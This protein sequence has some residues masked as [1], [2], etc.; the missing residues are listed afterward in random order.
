MIPTGRSGEGNCVIRR[1]QRSDH[2]VCLSEQCK[3]DTRCAPWARS[4]SDVVARAEQRIAKSELELR[5]LDTMEA[6]CDQR[7]RTDNWANTRALP[8]SAKG[9]QRTGVASVVNRKPANHPDGAVRR[10]CKQTL[11]QHY[12]KLTPCMPVR[13]RAKNN[14]VFISWS[15]E[16]SRTIATALQGFLTGLVPGVGV[17]SSLLLEPGEKWDHEI[18]KKLQESR[19]FILCLTSENLAAPWIHFEARGQRICPFLIDGAIMKNLQPPLSTYQPVVA[20]KKGSWTLV[21]SISRFFLRVSPSKA[22]EAAFSER[23]PRFNSA[24]RSVRVPPPPPPPPRPPPPKDDRIL[25]LEA[26][27][28][29][30]TVVC[31]WGSVV[32]P[33]NLDRKKTVFFLQAFEAIKNLVH[34]EIERQS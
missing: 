9:Y 14:L 2:P 1:S 18:E 4:P 30:I 12:D 17:W 22:D 21:Q 15:G 26:A 33:S 19:F 23:W 20:N 5:R 3:G 24:L 29:V 7:R 6:F 31:K 32:S 8:R 10:R 16:R 13:K 28:E 27:L 34:L 11:G 25:V